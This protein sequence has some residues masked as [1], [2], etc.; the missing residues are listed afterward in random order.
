MTHLNF[1]G[2]IEQGAVHLLA[3]KAGHRKWCDEFF[4]C[5]GH[6]RANTDAATLQKPNQLQAFVSCNAAAHACFEDV[7]DTQ[8]GGRRQGTAEAQPVRTVRRRV[9]DEEAIEDVFR[10]LIAT[11]RE[12][13]DA[14]AVEAERQVRRG[15][16]R[17]GQLAA[18][19]REYQERLAVREVQVEARHGV[20]EQR[21]ILASQ[22]PEDRGRI[23][24][25]RELEAALVE[26]SHQVLGRRG[27]E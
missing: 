26:G 1:V 18:Q 15:I 20:L 8:N 12:F 17:T 16:D 11:G 23:G 22:Q 24:Q 2:E 21:D 14:A 9:I 10:V 6:N 27:Q 4:R 19:A 25:E 5:F 13:A 3:R 7:R